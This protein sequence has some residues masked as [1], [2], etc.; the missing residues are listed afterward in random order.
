MEAV[1]K[2]TVMNA[3]F[4]ETVRRETGE[5]VFLCYQCQK[6]SSGCPVVEHFDLAPNQVMRAVQLGQKEMALNS[7]T[8][9]LC[10]MCETCAT[11]CPHDINITKIMDVLKI[12]AKNEG[13]EPKVPSV[14]LFYQAAL[15]GIKWFGRMYEA[16]LMGEIYLRQMM[17]GQLNFGQVW[18]N[19]M[20]L[21]LKM[22][23]NGKLNFFPT[24]G[25]PKS[26]VKASGQ[27]DGIAYFPGCS[28]HGTSKE[29]DLSTQAVF[30]KLGV[31]LHEPK[32]WGCCGTTPTHSTDHYL[33]TLLPL[34]NVALM[35]GEGFN[36]ITTP[37]PSC[38][39]RMRVAL[40]ETEED[41]HLRKRIRQA[42][43][44]LS[45]N[46]MKIEHLLNT[47]TEGVGYQ[48]V[49]SK[50]I[51]PLKGL[52]VVCYYGCII[53][54]PPK[55]TQV[56]DYEYPTNMDRLMKMLG[57]TS[58]DWSYKTRCCGV[59]LGI[60]QLPIALELSRKILRNAKSV[61]ADAIVVACPLCHV[62]LDARQKQIEEGF[63]ETF[64]LPIIYFTQLMGLAFGLKTEELGLDKHFVDPL[65][66][67][68]RLM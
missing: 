39:L 4:A 50:V 5:N 7:K 36:H 8:I 59:S 20:P 63:K 65:P 3:Q 64:Q 23:R 21:A 37:C 25:K 38:F 48:Q 19:D 44:N 13:I 42:I 24:F 17:S 46:G 40:K 29:Y 6:C 9:W 66:L 31:S 52:K 57:I 10:A 14:P 28:L 45:S 61:G 16:G 51:H 58:L 62:N 30:N 34:K 35:R 47:V 68:H 60:T 55:I 2:Q 33:S 12:M 11:R 27:K 49:G 54:R 67:L 43:P 32:G 18:K 41:E 26:K 22:F 56:K 53:T 15:R 1:R